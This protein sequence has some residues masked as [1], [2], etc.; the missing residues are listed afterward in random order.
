MRGCKVGRVGAVVE[1]P[2]GVGRPEV[3]KYFAILQ[4]QILPIV[5]STKNYYVLYY[6]RLM[7]WL[8]GISL[9]ILQ[10]LYNRILVNTIQPC[11]NTG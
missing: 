9:T 3:R 6:A 10:V 8:Q 7:I 5:S 4:Y 1:I 11:Y 2:S